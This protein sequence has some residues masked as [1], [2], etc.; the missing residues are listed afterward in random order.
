[1][2]ESFRVRATAGTL[3]GDPADGFALPHAWTEA[4]VVV[5]GAGTGA[6]VLHTAVALCVLNDLFR[7]ADRRGLALAG[8]AVAAEGGFDG[9]WS[10][11]GIRY[12]VELEAELSG[13]DREALLAAVDEV[14][15]IPR[16]LRAGVPVAR[17]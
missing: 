14:A 1:M 4:G 9:D 2:A 7:E 10:S 12:D 6:H 17:A 5:E 13:D 3:R 16:A 15:E 11:T 8:V